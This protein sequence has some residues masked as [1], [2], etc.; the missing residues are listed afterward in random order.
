MW[1]AP[2]DVMK[3]KFR[4]LALPE[5]RPLIP[6]LRACSSRMTSISATLADRVRPVQG[7][8]PQEAD[9]MI[10]KATA[11]LMAVGL[12]GSIARP[13]MAQ[14]MA[15]QLRTQE[16]PQQAISVESPQR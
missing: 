10:S 5:R 6:R 4:H 3:H 14:I 7:V 11:V 12:R 2:A 15:V 1:S 9:Q 8:N 16:R 13:P